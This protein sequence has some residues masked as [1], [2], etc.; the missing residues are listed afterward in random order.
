VSEPVRE[1]DAK[2]DPVSENG[3]KK[4]RAPLLGLRS[5]KRLRTVTC[6][7]GIGS[8]GVGLLYVLAGNARA[9]DIVLV[10]GGVL[11]TLASLVFMRRRNPQK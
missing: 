1:T 4:T 2:G 5:S 11:V 8:V 3:K 7:A 10:V 9:V 6:A